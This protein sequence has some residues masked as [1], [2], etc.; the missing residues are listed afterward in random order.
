MSL[1]WPA[2]LGPSIVHTSHHMVNFFEGPAMRSCDGANWTRALLSLTIESRQLTTSP[3][4]S[5]PINVSSSNP[6]LITQLDLWFCIISYHHHACKFPSQYQLASCS[7]FW[8]SQCSSGH[9]HHFL[10]LSLRDDENSAAFLKHLRQD[11]SLECIDKF[12]IYRCG[13]GILPIKNDQLGTS[14]SLVQRSSVHNLFVQVFFR[15][16]QY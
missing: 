2:V 3:S 11:N 16:C 4:T 9:S 15:N 6:L 1:H 12:S 7:F 5:E 14:I 13:Y 10:L 8:A